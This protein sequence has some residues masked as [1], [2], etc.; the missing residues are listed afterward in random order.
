MLRDESSMRETRVSRLQDDNKRIRNLSSEASRVLA[1][2]T[3]D[4]EEYGDQ[5][6]LILKEITISI[7]G[8]T[9]NDMKPTIYLEAIIKHPGLQ[10]I[11]LQ[12]G[13]WRQAEADALGNLVLDAEGV[14]V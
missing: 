2:T 12:R 10:Y 14:E 3:R 9:G 7:P 4:K 11:G 6:L 5:K 13:T 8:Q 1:E